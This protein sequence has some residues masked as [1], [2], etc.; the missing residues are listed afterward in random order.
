MRRFDQLDWTPIQNDGVT[1]GL[2][3]IGWVCDDGKK[4]KPCNGK[5]FLANGLLQTAADHF[6][7]G[8]LVQVDEAIG[9]P[10]MMTS[11]V[12]TRFTPA[13]FD[14]LLTPNDPVNLNFLSQLD[15]IADGYRFLQDQGVVAIVHAIPE[16]NGDWFWWSRGTPDRYRALF[17]LEFD[18]LTK[19]KGLHNLLFAYAPNAGNGAY[20]DNYPGDAYVDIVGLDY[21]LDVNGAIPKAGGYDELTTRVAPCKPFGFV[22][23]GPLPGGTQVFQARDYDQ[24]IVA[25]KQSMPRVTYWHSWKGVWGMGIAD[26]D[27][28]SRHLNVPELLHDPWVVN[29]GDIALTP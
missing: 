5:P 23:F 26:Y 1:P 20:G 22:E 3:G 7:R 2:V 15:V 14:H 27:A 16:M 19:T 9:N 12:D 8:G 25:I 29:L 6:H 10:A 11:A 18:Y 28:G 13:D 17:R 4:T 21:Y 24:L